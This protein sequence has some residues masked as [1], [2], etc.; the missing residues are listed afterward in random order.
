MLEGG[1]PGHAKA[2]EE[3]HGG[4]VEDSEGTLITVSRMAEKLQRWFCCIFGAFSWTFQAF[5]SIPNCRKKQELRLASCSSIERCPLHAQRTTC[6]LYAFCLHSK[7]LCYSE[8]AQESSQVL[9][10]NE[11]LA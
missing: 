2:C 4:Q 7:L 5:S 10:R 6:A 8:S 11:V 3:G 1:Y 9:L